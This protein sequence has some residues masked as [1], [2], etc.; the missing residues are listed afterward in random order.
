MINQYTFVLL[1]GSIKDIDYAYKVQFTSIKKYVKLEDLHS[2]IIITRDI[3]VSYVKDTYNDY[4]ESYNIKII[5]ENIIYKLYKLDDIFLCSYY[6]Q[7]FLKLAI[8]KLI[9]TDIYITLDA[10]VYIINNLSMNNLILENKCKYNKESF[11]IHL[12]WWENAYK[13]LNYNIKD[14]DFTNGFGVTPSIIYKDIVHKLDNYI[15]N[16]TDYNLYT[17]FQLN[18]T[19]YTLYWVYI[20]NHNYINKYINYDLSNCNKNVWFK[21]DI[22]YNNNTFNFKKIKKILKEQ[23]N[24]TN[25]FFSLFQSTSDVI[26]S[27]KFIDII[28]E[29]I[30]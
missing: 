11:N 13:S 10:D 21:E 18:A 19:E 23:F 30:T 9:E 17:I 12:T 14:A 7:M 24:E 26:Y 8:Y 25:T 2:F 5:N 27:N 28:N 4:I 16:N 3:Y 29:Y 15:I 22:M 6:N 20:L 1:L